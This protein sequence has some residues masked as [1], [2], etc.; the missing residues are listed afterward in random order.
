V[1][2]AGRGVAGLE[3]LLA[4]RAM[5]G[6]RVDITILAPE[7]KFVNRS[8]ASTSP[9]TA[10]LCRDSAFGTSRPISTPD[11]TAVPSGASSKSGR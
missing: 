4:L 8:M 9:R 7:L 2:I 5:A 6:N 3:T 10:A 1:L 11:G